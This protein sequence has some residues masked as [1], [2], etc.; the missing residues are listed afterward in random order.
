MVGLNWWVAEAF[1]V[2]HK[3]LYDADFNFERHVKSV[4]A[5]DWRGSYVWEKQVLLK[6]VSDGM[7]QSQG[8]I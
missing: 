1:W 6:T 4:D 3:L 7:W 5:S 2:Y 8:S